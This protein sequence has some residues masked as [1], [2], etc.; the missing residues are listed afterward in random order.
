MKKLKQISSFALCI[1]LISCTSNLSINTNEYIQTKESKISKSFDIDLASNSNIKSNK[2]IKVKLNLA[3]SFNT[4]GYINKKTSKDIKSLVVWLTKSTTDPGLPANVVTGTIFKF[5]V[6]PD[7]IKN[8]DLEYEFNFKNI[9]ETSTNIYAAAQAYSLP[10]SDGNWNSSNITKQVAPLNES[11]CV[12][13]SYVNLDA[14]YAITFNPPTATSLHVNLKLLDTQKSSIVE[15]IYNVSSPV[16]PRSWD[17]SLDNAGNGMIVWKE[18]NGAN[19]KI[20]YAIINDFL[21]PKINT[22]LIPPA[23]EPE[24]YV[25]PANISSLS[26][27]SVSLNNLGNGFIF[28]SGYDT[29]SSSDQIFAIPVNN[30]KPEL[31]DEMNITVFSSGRSVYEIDSEIIQTGDSLIVFTTNEFSPGGANKNIFGIKATNDGKNPP[32]NTNPQAFYINNNEK[33]NPKISINELG[34]GI[35]VW[36]EK[37]G[38]KNDIFAMPLKDLDVPEITTTGTMSGNISTSNLIGSGAF[39]KT[40]LT[41][42]SRISQGTSTYTV[43]NVSSDTNATVSPS[44]FSTFSSVPLKGKAITKSLS[45]TID[46]TS[47]TP[48][49]GTGTN[50]INELKIGERVILLNTSTSEKQELI[51]NYIQT[52]PEQIGFL[53]PI[54][55]TTGNNCKLFKKGDF[56]ITNDVSNTDDSK[57]PNVQVDSEMKSM[58]A[59][60]EDNISNQTVK[61]VLFEPLSTTPIGTIQPFGDDSTL[62]VS[63]ILNGDDNNPPSF[64]IN[65]VGNG[66]IL[67]SMKNSTGERDIYRRYINNYNPY[68]S[69]TVITSATSTTPYTFPIFKMQIQTPSNVPPYNTNGAYFYIKQDTSLSKDYIELESKDTP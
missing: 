28:Y 12:S 51:V 52:S 45:G 14:N 48:Y 3:N 27:V 39:F 26:K 40:Q 60:K 38:T 7:Y 23:I 37:I 32:S 17:L 44:F 58:I 4:K 57:F 20:K 18:D 8:Y 53:R 55:I 13:S 36:N 10:K 41:K 15:S 69:T 25:L 6:N 35:L 67:W 62:G 9:A 47:G 43:T 61:G 30:Y 2:S 65:N 50:F 22:S 11:S 64:Y 34:Q 68:N 16:S 19:K 33:N 31:L 29:G 56:M 63:T 49:N 5:D 59:W 46:T 24:E 21:P 1:M 66:E 54:T 42:G